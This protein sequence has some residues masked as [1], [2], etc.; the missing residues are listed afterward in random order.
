MLDINSFISLRNLLELLATGYRDSVNK[1]ISY[2][3]CDGYLT[4]EDEFIEYWLP[5]AEREN[6]IS[7]A[8]FNLNRAI[9]QD[10]KGVPELWELDQV[11]GFHVKCLQAM[12]EVIELLTQTTI[13]AK[14]QHRRRDSFLSQWHNHPERPLFNKHGE[15]FSFQ[16]FGDWDEKENQK[17]PLYTDPAR[18]IIRHYTPPIKNIEKL[19][20]LAFVK[21]D[22]V[23]FLDKHGIEHSLQTEQIFN[24]IDELYPQV[25]KEKDIEELRLIANDL[26]ST[27]KD[28][29]VIAALLRD[30]H[31]AKHW[32]IVIIL[33]IELPVTSEAKD[34]QKSKETMAS[35]SVAKGRKALKARSLI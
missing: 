31:G 27:E 25:G 29:N 20:L 8:A 11:K 23:A 2:L 9:H 6:S 28:Q 10:E 32:Q 34:P 18:Q 24:E 7:D 35:R 16:F 19:D 13:M 1:G 33:K 17:E 12:P 14:E 5:S 4:I 22:A 3:S 30:E 26:K 15:M 21:K